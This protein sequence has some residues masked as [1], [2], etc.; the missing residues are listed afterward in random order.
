[1]G[2]PGRHSKVHNHLLPDSRDEN[3]SAQVTLL[4][5]VDEFTPALLT[6]PSK[7]GLLQTFIFASTDIPL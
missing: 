6:Q 2:N 7:I 5:A 3:A 1:M 4:M